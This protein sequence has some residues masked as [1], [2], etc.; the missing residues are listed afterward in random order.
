MRKSDG[1]TLVEL[2][3]VIV[4]LAILAVVAIPRFLSAADDAQISKM[5]A[6]AGAFDQAVKHARYLWV[7][8]G[9]PGNTNGNNRR[10]P[11]VD[12]DGRLVTVDAETGWPV[13]SAGRDTGTNINNSADCLTV[14][15]DVMSTTMKIVDR[16]NRNNPSSTA[17]TGFDILV[18]RTN[19]N[20]NG[21]QCNYYLIE[22]IP[23]ESRNPS[24]GAP[25]QY[26]GFSY[27]AQTG[28]VSTFD[29]ING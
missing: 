15:S 16:V 10:G 17:R 25:T 20:A 23:Q 5:K 6:V 7:V 12:Y 13:G 18:T 24:E 3:I 1:F 8:A 28:Q 21:D 19:D 14:F 2:V 22:T 29:F 9:K 4:I 11:Q 27:N 26:M